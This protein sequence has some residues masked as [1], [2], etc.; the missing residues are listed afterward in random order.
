MGARDDSLRELSTADG[1][2]ARRRAHLKAK[3]V[4][5]VVCA[6]LL[7]L[8]AMAQ[9]KSPCELPE[10]ALYE[11]A[12]RLCADEMPTSRSQC[13]AFLDELAAVES[14]S[15][16]Q[17]LSL[18]YGRAF[19]LQA[20]G[21]NDAEAA[22]MERAG[23]EVLKPFVDAAP[24]D[25]M[26]LYAY[27][28]F[29]HDNEVRHREL[30][31]KVVAIDPTCTWA[32][33]WLYESLTRGEDEPTDAMIDE[34]IM[35]LKHGYEH[36]EGTK[37]LFFA[38]Q[39]HG[40]LEYDR[41][42]DAKAFRERVATDMA[43]LELPLDAD[44]RTRSLELLCHGNGLRVRLEGPCWSAISEL[45]G[46]DRMANAP[47]ADDVLDAVGSLAHAARYGEL[48]DESMAYLERLQQLLEAEPDW[49]RT[50]DFYALYSRIV[51]TTI[52]Y[53]A[54]VEA[55]RRALTLDPGSGEIGLSLGRALNRAGRPAYIIREAYQHVIDNAEDAESGTSADDYARLATE[56]LRELEAEEMQGVERRPADPESPDGWLTLD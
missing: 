40:A 25:P 46:R 6:A 1:G 11:K 55:L 22:E 51:V 4:V 34:S 31:R 7:P 48:G 18:A 23:R 20:D 19:A 2:V 44:N 3:W 29:H 32:A 15:L 33:Y 37:K 17:A 9:S 28:S 53:D 10:T 42:D 24:N 45:A 54:Q 26:L 14:P 5:A 43:A 21:Y 56:R 39:T 50:A 47:L 12:G 38:R 49:Q 52:G 35:Y 41:P 13:H 27:S 36:A 8:G 16:D 30:L